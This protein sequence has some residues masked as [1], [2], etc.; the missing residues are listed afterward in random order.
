MSAHRFEIQAAS[1]LKHP[2]VYLLEVG[3]F[4]MRIE[5]VGPRRII[6]EQW[7]QSEEVSEG[8]ILDWIAEAICKMRY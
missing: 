5:G 3:G 6:V 7:G 4:R 2:G 1:R 8:Q